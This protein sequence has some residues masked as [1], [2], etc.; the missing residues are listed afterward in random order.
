MNHSNDTLLHDVTFYS[1]SGSS[2]IITE[3]FDSFTNCSTAWGCEEI[4]WRFKTIGLIF[5]TRWET[6]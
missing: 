1:T 5:P 3:N 4:S 6:I 2:A